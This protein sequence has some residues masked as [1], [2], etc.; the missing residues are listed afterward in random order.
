MQ[1]KS[2]S[3]LLL[4]CLFCTYVTVFSM[5]QENKIELEI[6]LFKAVQ[7]GDFLRVK[8]L[9]QEKKV[10]VDII[11]EENNRLIDCAVKNGHLDIVKYLIEECNVN[12]QGFSVSGLSLMHL[13]SWKGHL[14]IVKYLEK[15]GLSVKKECYLVFWSPIRYVVENG[16]IDLVR[17]FIEEKG[18][19]INT[20]NMSDNTL[21]EMAFLCNKLQVLKYLIKKGALI[22]DNLIKM[23]IKSENA[24]VEK[25]YLD[26][27]GKI[28]GFKDLDY[29]GQY[30]I[31]S[32][33]LKKG[34]KENK[35]CSYLCRF[36]MRLFPGC[37]NDEKDRRLFLLNQDFIVCKKN[38]MANKTKLSFRYSRVC[39]PK[40]LLFK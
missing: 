17:Y 22:R 6:K 12:V 15:K 37:D 35:I 2:F 19:D 4:F 32:Q 27:L 24:G 38:K 9:I 28:R 29:E 11:D 26:I 5:K 39:V 34:N 16:H 30:S 8:F 20:V 33:V 21:I 14:D 3:I 36:F 13:A 31:V 23:C 10:R 1:V 25:K 7:Q 18:V 40:I